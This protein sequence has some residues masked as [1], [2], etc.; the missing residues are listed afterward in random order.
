MS[1]STAEVTALS[2]RLDW[3]KVDGMVPAIVQDFTSSQVLM[4]GT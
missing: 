1:F 2:E 3:D 4:M